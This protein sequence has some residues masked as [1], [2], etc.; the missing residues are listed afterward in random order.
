MALLLSVAVLFKLWPIA[1]AGL[2]CLVYPRQLSW[3]LAI[4]LAA[5]FAAPFALQRPAYVMDQYRQWATFQ[6]RRP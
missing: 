3:R 2:L 4:A 1:I 6:P 5:G